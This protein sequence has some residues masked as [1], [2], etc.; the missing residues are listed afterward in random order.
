MSAILEITIKLPNLSEVTRYC[1]LQEDLRCPCCAAEKT[2]YREMYDLDYDQTAYC[3]E[4]GWHGVI[5]DYG[6]CNIIN[7]TIQ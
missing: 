3:I 4:C 7:H 6:R 1:F 5:K 2:I